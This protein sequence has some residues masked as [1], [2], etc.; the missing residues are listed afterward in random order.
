[1]AVRGEADRMGL[2][3]LCWR[4]SACRVSPTPLR[5]DGRRPLGAERER[6]AHRRERAHGEIGVAAHGTI[7]GACAEDDDARGDAA[8]CGIERL[9]PSARLARS[10]RESA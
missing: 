3:F 4:R 9:S 8:D 10:R 2:S 5:F 1:M 7:E 6:R